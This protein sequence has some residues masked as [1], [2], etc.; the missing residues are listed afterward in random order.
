MQLDDLASESSGEEDEHEFPEQSLPTQ[1]SHRSPEER[2]SFLFGHNLNP[3]ATS[4]R[5]FHPLPSQVPF[6]LDVFSENI[7]SI[8]RIVHVPTIQ[9]MVRE[10]RT[11]EMTAVNEALMFSIYYATIV[12]MEEDDVSVCS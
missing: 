8:L 12:S 4:L 11:K 3:A 5:D 2:N 1:E 10:S 9:K 7:N 6:L